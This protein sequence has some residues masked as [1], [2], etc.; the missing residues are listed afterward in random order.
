M[1]RLPFGLPND[2]PFPPVEADDIP[3]HGHLPSATHPYLR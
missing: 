3:P 2:T 1:G